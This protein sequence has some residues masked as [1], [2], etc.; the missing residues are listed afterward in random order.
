MSSELKME[1][2]FET[3]DC[4]THGPQRVRLF[5]LF[6]DWAPARCPVCEAEQEQAR[7]DEEAARQIRDTAE[8]RDRLIRK[9]LQHAAVPPRFEGK[10]FAA[11]TATD[12]SSAKALATCRSYADR[13]LDH[14]RTGTSLILCGNAGTG[15]THLAC[16]VADQVIR[17]HSKAAVYMTAGRAFR[18][19]KDT[20]RKNSQVSEQDALSAFAA[21]DLL[22][23]DEIGVQYGSD[24]ERNILFEIVN[25]RYEQM[26]PTV[27]ISNLALPALTEF[28]G[29]RVIDRLKEN[30]GKLIVFDWKSH[31]GAA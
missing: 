12:S 18:K 17:N 30:G 14:L 28:A 6:A 15:K 16:A 22:I 20:Y 8:H 4:P 24:A 23:L 9:H 26:K 7:S 21:P 25:E 3:L 11:F 5:R 1:E 27:L 29:E 31:R 19:V 10:S 13:F 2:R